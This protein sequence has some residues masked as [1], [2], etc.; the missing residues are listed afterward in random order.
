MKMK[1][2][3]TVAV[4]T[5]TMGITSGAW[6]A[7][8]ANIS[9]GN[10]YTID[11]VRMTG[12]TAGTYDGEVATK[13]YVDA[14]GTVTQCTTSANVLPGQAAAACDTA[15]SGSRPANLQEFVQC[16][17]STWAT[18]SATMMEPISDG[19]GGLSF[20]YVFRSDHGTNADQI[21]MTNVSSSTLGSVWLCVK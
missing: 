1:K 7:C 2:L 3:L 12:D 14:V 4:V 21:R 10:A 20:P 19:S 9:M 18:T 16:P 17:S 6:A 11:D 5:A 8:S 13:T 15:L